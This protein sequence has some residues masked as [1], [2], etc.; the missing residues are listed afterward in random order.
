M[1]S[2][3]PALDPHRIADGAQMQR[4]A[5]RLN[6]EMRRDMRRPVSL[7]YR[8]ASSGDASLRTRRAQGGLVTQA[9]RAVARSTR[10]GFES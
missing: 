7:R 2:I 4:N 9:W 3:D 8:P 6:E 1:T 5:R 10:S